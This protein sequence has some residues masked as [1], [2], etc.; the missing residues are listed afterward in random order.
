MAKIFIGID[1]SIRELGLAIGE[2]DDTTKQLYVY[3]ISQPSSAIPYFVRTR[4][5]VKTVVATIFGH[6]NEGDEVYFLSETPEHWV[7]QRG[8]DSESGSDIQTLY[9]LV[10]ELIGWARRL[11]NLKF[12]GVV[13]PSTWKGQV[14]KPIMVA[15]A[16]KYA[17]T[18]WGRTLPISIKDDACEAVLL[19]R[20]LFRCLKA[21]Q[22]NTHMKVID[23]GASSMNERCR[24]SVKIL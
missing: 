12:I 9:Y 22:E 6:I 11:P 14:K 21:K 10:G 4:E 3:Q 15:R 2:I 5:M 19:L 24:V 16:K 18:A 17:E 23:V 1:P 8:L 7:S 13:P 20:H